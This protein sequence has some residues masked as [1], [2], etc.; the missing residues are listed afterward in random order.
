MSK[1][2][3]AVFFLVAMGVAISSAVVYGTLCTIEVN[4]AYHAVQEMSAEVAMKTNLHDL[5][6]ST[7]R[8]EIWRKSLNQEENQT[9]LSLANIVHSPDFSKEKLSPK[10]RALITRAIREADALG[11]FDKANKVGLPNMEKME[12]GTRVIVWDL[13][14]LRRLM[15]LDFQGK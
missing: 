15:G 4:K 2:Q 1:K 6:I 3:I 11:L 13:N 7:E 12:L 14:S 8:F 9:F 10:E 5:Y